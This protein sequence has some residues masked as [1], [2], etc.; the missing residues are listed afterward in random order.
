L[1]YPQTIGNAIRMSPD[2]VE[3]RNAEIPRDRDVILYCT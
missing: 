2:E 1:P 3:A